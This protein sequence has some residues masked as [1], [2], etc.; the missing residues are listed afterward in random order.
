MM[1]IE[2]H[3]VGFRN[4]GARLMLETVLGKLEHER[5]DIRPS[6]FLSE[7]D[8]DPRASLVS[9]TVLGDLRGK[10]LSELGGRFARSV[11]QSWSRATT[12]YGPNSAEAC[13]ALIDISGFLL[14]DQWGP[15]KAEAFADLVETYAQR[16]APVLLLPQSFGPFGDARVA[17]AV[18]RVLRAATVIFARDELSASH[19]E[20]ILPAARIYIAPD[21]TLFHPPKHD[22]PS[23]GG[24]TVTIVP[25]GRI[26]DRAGH[27]W[28][29]DGFLR[30]LEVSVQWTLEQGFQ[31]QVLLHTSELKDRRLAEQLARR[32][33]H[34]PQV[35]APSTPL[36]AKTLLAD[37]RLVVGAR[38]HALAGAMSR[39]TP[40]I[41]LGWSHKYEH[42]FRDFQVP[43]L[44]LPD[45]A[46]EDVVWGALDELSSPDAVQDLQGRLAR[47]LSGMREL[48]EAMWA[49]ALGYLPQP[50]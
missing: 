23:N 37:S 36:E 17:R 31:P 24:T 5:S 11:T 48:N 10:V 13:A 26:A 1:N 42:L 20:G 21:I 30:T 22:P 2:I 43:G 28:T 33:T 34:P 40:A 50:G 6:V 49:Q 4:L 27:G 14:S 3:G 8:F 41:G 16:D 18:K 9:R 32:T 45:D 44:L 39:G 29:L 35:I 12:S 19:L 47:P 38:Y 46:S 25:N 7:G 15:V